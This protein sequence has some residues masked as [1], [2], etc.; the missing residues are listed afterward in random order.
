M[1]PASEEIKK[2]DVTTSLELKKCFVFDYETGQHLI[3]D[4]KFVECNLKQ[5]IENYVNTIAR[6]EVDKFKIYVE[7]ETEDFGVSIYK[8]I[9]SRLTNQGFLLAEL[10]RELTEQFE[11]HYLIKEVL[12]FESSFDKNNLIIEFELLLVDGSTFNNRLE[13]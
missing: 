2:E 4:G 10:K 9:G 7:D 1:F 3:I 8:N 12:K 13:V 11:Q 5:T 6:T